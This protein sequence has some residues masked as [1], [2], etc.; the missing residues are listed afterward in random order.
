MAI[1]EASLFLRLL[2]EEDKGSVLAAV[3]GHVRGGAADEHV[4]QVA[5]ESFRQVPGAP[6]AYW[7]GEGMRGLFSRLPVFEGKGRTVKQ[8][9]ATADDFRFVHAVWEVP[10]DDVGRRWRLF[11]K[12]GAYSPF[13]ADVHLVV[14]WAKN[15]AE[16]ANFLDPRTGK[17]CS[18][19]QNTKYYLRPG[20]TWPRRTQSG[21]A[22]RAMPA[23]CIFA[24]KGPAAFV[25]NDNPEALLALLAITNSRAFRTLVE[26]QMAFGSYEVGVIQRTPVPDISE[27]DR[28]TLAH[29]AHRAWSVKRAVDTAE[30]T[31]HA[32]VLPALLQAPGATLAERAAAWSARLTQAEQELA[33]AQAH[34]DERCF[35]LY[36]F[37]VQDREAAVGGACEAEKVPGGEGDE[38]GGAPADAT[39]LAAALLDWLVGA[40]FGR[41]DVRLAASGREPP[42]EPEPFDPLPV[43]SPGMLADESGLPL[44][45]APAGYPLELPPGGMLVDDPGLEGG[46]P[47]E[48][49]IVRRLRAV[50]EAVF[51][52]QA[53]EVEAELCQMLG[54]RDL[55]TYLR[56]P[57]G[58]F[59]DHL[60]RYSKSR[61]K[62]PIYWPLSTASGSY[63]I[64]I[65]YP[66]LTA[67]T[68]YQAVS[69]HLAPKVSEVESR[70]SQL[71]ADLSKA[72]GREASRLT[73]QLGTL[74]ELL[75]ELQDLREELLR[76]ARLPYKLDLNDGVQITAAPLWRVFRL[77]KWRKD[78]ERTWK[79]L[80]SG[81]HDWAH[82]AFAIWPERV[83]ERCRTDRSIAIAHGLE[84]LYEAPPEGPARAGRRGGT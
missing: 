33:E 78:L 15:G 10:G 13:Y 60:S 25:E 24:D 76:V 37:A 80:E 74:A 50:L 57:S 21:L 39:A 48:S 68:L 32:F 3:L 58:F 70:I 55:R 22:L 69:S 27:D 54:V 79:A 53:S 8:G 31:S 63:T 9:L 23:G 81:E 28:R 16:V 43:C 2:A 40:A 18:R 59:A 12:G 11:V 26:F 45:E 49:D 41:F 30:L 66:R 51:A 4:F 29:L 34:I 17:I 72:E 5:P 77:K 52:E 64:W 56:K 75:E 20:L 47:A 36:G 14:N 62:A 35:D 38:E 82:L 65:Y 67:D 84:A 42:P 19:P 1:G 46:V 71:E 6:F 73:R 83:R 7:V 44:A 61:R